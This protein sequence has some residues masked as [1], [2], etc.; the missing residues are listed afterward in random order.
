MSNNGEG[1]FSAK[2]GCPG[3]GRFEAASS[4]VR[5][6]ASIRQNLIVAEIL[7]R[8]VGFKAHSRMEESGEYTVA[9]PPID[10]PDERY[11]LTRDPTHAP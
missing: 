7:V 6:S 9:E 11:H 4:S 2:R 8:G 1:P 5:S 10:A 3:T